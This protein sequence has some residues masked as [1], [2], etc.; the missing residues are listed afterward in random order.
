MIQMAKEIGKYLIS[1]LLLAYLFFAFLKPT[2]DKI[3]GR[4]KATLAAEEAA[5]KE[6]EKE[7]EKRI[8]EEEAAIVNLTSQDEQEKTPASTYETNMEMARQ[9]AAN[10]PKI[11]ANVIK[12]WVSN[13]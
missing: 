1:A 4:D 2:L 9:L 11:V 8:E 12:A 5:R 3:M 10:D 6:L 13:E 7:E